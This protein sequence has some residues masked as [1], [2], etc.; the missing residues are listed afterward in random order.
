MEN[1]EWISAD[2]YDGDIPFLSDEE[3]RMRAA[4]RQAKVSEALDDELPFGDFKDDGEKI[5]APVRSE[6]V[7]K[8]PFCGSDVVDKE[9]GY[10]CENYDCKFVLWK[11]NRFFDAITKEMTRDVA[12]KILSDGY[13]ELTGCKSV[14]T[15]KKFNCVV[16]V[17]P[18]EENRPHYVMDFP[19]KKTEGEYYGRTE[20]R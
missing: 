14:R 11:D 5:K 4:A 1:N 13:V 17:K 7:G 12:E 8:C 18:D 6:V 15:G 3:N 9:K 16:S 20:S 2:D 19:K 10:F